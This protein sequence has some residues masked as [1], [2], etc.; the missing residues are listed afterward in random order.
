MILQ[1]ALFSPMGITIPAFSVRDVL[2][3]PSGKEDKGYV[4]FA[5]AD[6]HKIMYKHVY[7]NTSWVIGIMAMCRQIRSEIKNLLSSYDIN[8]HAVD[9]DKIGA[10]QHGI[11]RTVPLLIRSVS[12]FLGKTSGRVVLWENW[13]GHHFPDYEKQ[14]RKGF[15]PAPRVPGLDNSLATYAQA[16]QPLQLFIGLSMTYHEVSGA[17]DLHLCKQDAPVTGFECRRIECIVPVSDRVNARKMVDEAVDRRLD[18]LR[19]HFPHRWCYVRAMRSKLEGGLALA[20]Q[21]MREEV[22]RI[23]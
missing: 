16:V 4:F 11:S 17:R 19:C 12:P 15:S 20:R 13:D 2:N 6:P 8:V 3:V 21:Y 5:P 9:F 1:M 10:R 23:C 22:D 18:L 14:R 7:T